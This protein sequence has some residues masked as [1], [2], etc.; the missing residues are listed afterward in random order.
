M[1]PKEIR[2][3]LRLEEGAN[4][5]FE[6]SGETIMVRPEP[7]PEEAVERFLRVKGRKR[8]KLVDWKSV[9]DE[10]YRLPAGR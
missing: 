8:R 7:S 6:V 9:V 3:K 2:E 10:E 1:I 4:L 5:T